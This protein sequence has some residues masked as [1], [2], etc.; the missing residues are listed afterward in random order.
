MGIKQD[1]AEIIDFQAEKEKKERDSMTPEQKLKL[2][3]LQYIIG[4]KEEVYA[5]LKSKNISIDEMF[6][7]LAEFTYG[8][9]KKSPAD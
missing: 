2:N 9:Y 5:F 3:L 7:L 4:S 6:S 1:K 8:K